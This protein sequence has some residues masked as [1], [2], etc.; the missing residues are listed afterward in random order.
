MD[1]YY[2]AYGSN[3]NPKRM[4]ARGLVYDH[5]ARGLLDHHELKFN[6]KASDL[7]NAGYANVEP[8][9]G[10]I[11]EGVLYRLVDDQQI[12]KMDPFEGVPT[13]Y[14]REVM[15]IEM[16]GHGFVESWIYIAHPD[17]IDN[18]LLPEAWYVDHLLAGREMLSEDYYRAL[19]EVVVQKNSV[20]PW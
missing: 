2:F 6:K 13:L 8:S 20:E 16:H 10:N 18:T 17:R 14:T 11:V 3:M 9:Q 19:T 5:A 7:E 1:E 4:A 12:F 15:E